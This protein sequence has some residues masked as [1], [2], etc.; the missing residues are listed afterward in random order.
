M[1]STCQHGLDNCVHWRRNG[2]MK[3]RPLKVSPRSAAVWNSATLFIVFLSIASFRILSDPAVGCCTAM[4]TAALS[5]PGQLLHCA[6]SC[7]TRL[8]DSC[9]TMVRGTRSGLLDHHDPS[10]WKVAGPSAMA[11]SHVV[12]PPLLPAWSLMH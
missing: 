2:G 4:C 9:V 5:A 7:V 3:A 11:P 10:A 6:Q 12:A 1:Q 8:A